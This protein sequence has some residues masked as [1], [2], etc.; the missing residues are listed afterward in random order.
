[1]SGYHKDMPGQIPVS[2]THL[3][4][5][6]GLTILPGMVLHF[7]V[8]RPKSV[9]AVEKAMV[10][11]QRLFLVAQRHPEI[12][13][14]ELGELFQVGTVAVVKQLVKLPGKV[15]RVLVEGLERGELLCLD[16]EE[17]A[18]I[19]EIGSIETVSYTHLAIAACVVG[20]VSFTGGIGKIS[21]VV[22]GVLIFTVLIY[23]LTILG[24]DTNLQ[25]VFEGIIIIT[26]VTL[27]CLKYVQKT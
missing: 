22:V 14:P 21:G 11:D 8:N 7:D 2:Y 16:S 5:L 17:P 23:S 3:V 27:D 10:G 9:A 1:M 26:A 4:A 12:V 13:D 18:L 25:F 24:I 19:G 20:G 15:V 6:R